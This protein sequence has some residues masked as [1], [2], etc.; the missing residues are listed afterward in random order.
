MTRAE[1]L[2]AVEAIKGLVADDE[3]AHSCE[4][5][6]RANFIA[7]VAGMPGELGELAKIVLSTD[8]ISFSRWH[9]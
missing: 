3:A 8:E 4:D 9:G 2:A 1:A 6:L 5:G 7:Y